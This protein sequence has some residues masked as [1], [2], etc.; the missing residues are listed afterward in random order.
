LAPCQKALFFPLFFDFS[1]TLGYIKVLL[2]QAGKE[3]LHPKIK[4][5]T[6]YSELN[7]Q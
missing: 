7:R 1:N 5:G 2:R 3:P 4:K 6:F